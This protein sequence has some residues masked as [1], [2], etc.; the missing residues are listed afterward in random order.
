MEVY[1]KFYSVGVEYFFEVF[2]VQVSNF[3]KVYLL[4]TS[5]VDFIPPFTFSFLGEGI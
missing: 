4:G 5:A 1:V 2:G 3:P